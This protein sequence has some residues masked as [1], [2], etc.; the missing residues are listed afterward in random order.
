MSDNYLAVLAGKQPS[1][2]QWVG[3]EEDGIELAKAHVRM[4]PGE[5]S[6]VV[7]VTRMYNAVVEAQEVRCD[8]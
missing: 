6:Y 1:F 7:R 3:C 4:H 2:L 8:V 5:K